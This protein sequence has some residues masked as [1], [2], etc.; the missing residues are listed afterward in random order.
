MKSAAS[1]SDESYQKAN[2]YLD[3]L[4]H[5]PYLTIFAWILGMLCLFTFIILIGVF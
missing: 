2:Q 5:A 1:H 4:N 3:R